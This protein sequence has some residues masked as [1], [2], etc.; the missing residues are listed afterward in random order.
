MG[1]TLADRLELS[2]CK[3]VESTASGAYP[4][5]SCIRALSK[6][7]THTFSEPSVFYRMFVC[8]FMNFGR[9]GQYQ[10]QFHC[11]VFHYKQI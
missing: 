8:A 7:F 1:D 3:H 9:R 4:E 10:K 6:S 5:K 11:M 2:A